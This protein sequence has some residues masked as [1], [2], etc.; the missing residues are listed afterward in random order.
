MDDTP[1]EM[2]KLISF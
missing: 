2:H 1:D